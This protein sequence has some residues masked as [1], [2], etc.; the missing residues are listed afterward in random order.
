LAIESS[1][2]PH[3]LTTSSPAPFQKAAHRSMVS[4]QH[5]MQVLG[6]FSKT[7]R[8]TNPTRTS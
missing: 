5:E 4:D 8:T 3:E 2:E 7:S 6:A 1:L